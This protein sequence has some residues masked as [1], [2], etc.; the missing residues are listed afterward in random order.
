MPILE[1]CPARADSSRNAGIRIVHLDI[2]SL[3]HPT[4]CAQVAWTLAS[5]APLIQGGIKMWPSD[6]N[7]REYLGLQARLSSVARF[8]VCIIC[9]AAWVPSREGLALC[10]H[11]HLTR[12]RPVLLKQSRRATVR[13]SASPPCSSATS[14]HCSRPWPLAA[15]SCSAPT[16]V[17]RA[18]GG[19]SPK[20]CKQC[21]QRRPTNS[22]CLGRTGAGA[23]RQRLTPFDA[24]Q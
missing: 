14:K 5:C 15:S 3:S 17:G 22:M 11:L 13:P 7:K 9:S 8:M 21:D 12:T 10:S 20:Y 6:R 1:T 18:P 4:R 16:L 23:R 2:S 24:G 19:R